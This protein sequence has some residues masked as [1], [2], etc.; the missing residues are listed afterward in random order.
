MWLLLLF[1]RPES[2]RMDVTQRNISDRRCLLR[3]NVL[4]L[5]YFFCCRN[6]ILIGFSGCVCAADDSPLHS[7]FTSLRGSDRTMEWPQQQ[8]D[9]TFPFVVL[10]VGHTCYYDDY[11]PRIFGPSH[12]LACCF[13]SPAS[14]EGPFVWLEMR[15]IFPLKETVD[16]SA[17]SSKQKRFCLRSGRRKKMRRILCGNRN[18]YHG[19]ISGFEMLPIGQM[20]FSSM[21][22]GQL[23]SAILST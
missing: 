12:H 17:L 16:D 23:L 4:E 14:A 10:N 3:K 6:R 21:S 8:V 5:L 11:W 9:E 1:V 18:E 13:S 2:V 20:L 22:I 7:H 15:R 19:L